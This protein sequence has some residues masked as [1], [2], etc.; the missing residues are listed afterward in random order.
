MHSRI[1]LRGCARPSVTRELDIWEIGSLDRIRTDEEHDPQ[2]G[3]QL[4]PEQ[5]K[6]QSKAQT[7]QHV[8]FLIDYLYLFLP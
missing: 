8:L 1:S 7:F 6:L 5:C 2:R 4:P 3:F